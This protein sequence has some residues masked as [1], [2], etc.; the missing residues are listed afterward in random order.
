MGRAGDARGRTGVGWTSG[1]R[2]CIR[3]ARS[4]SAGAGFAH[5]GGQLNLNCVVSI[6]SRPAISTYRHL[7]QLGRRGRAGEAPARCRV[8]RPQLEVPAHPGRPF[9]PQPLISPRVP[10]CSREPGFLRAYRLPGRALP[11]R[12]GAKEALSCRSGGGAVAVCAPASGPPA[13]S[14]HGLA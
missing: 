3:P 5:P 12:P 9:S 11:P 6:K 4:S 13:C 10:R 1:E 7:Q 8:A 14:A 2:S